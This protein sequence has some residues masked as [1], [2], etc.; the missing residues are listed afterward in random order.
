ME[1]PHL[2]TYVVNFANGVE[3]FYPSTRGNRQVPK[4]PTFLLPTIPLVTQVL[5][6]FF[7]C[8]YIWAVQIITGVF[9][10]YIC[11]WFRVIRLLS[12]WGK[13]GMGNLLRYYSDAEGPG[14]CGPGVFIA[15][16]ADVAGDKGSGN[17]T[18]VDVETQ[19]VSFM[20]DF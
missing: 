12:I 7:Y 17:N 15:E 4:Y 5:S 8:S 10:L 14:R 1:L 6:Y 19:L 16:E 18:A 11:C 13:R 9:P 2:D 20:V 3:L